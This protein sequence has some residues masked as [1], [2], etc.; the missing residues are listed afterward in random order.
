VRRL[1]GWLV[2]AVGLLNGGRRER[3][4]DDEIES[5]VQMHAD[6]YMRRGLAPDE[7][8]RAAVLKLGSVQAIREQYHDQ[9][10]IPLLEH[11]VQDVR[12]AA[13]TLSRSAGVTAI[14]ILTIALGIAGPT[15]TFTMA[16]AWILE[17]LPFARPAE[18]LDIRNLDKVTGNYGSIAAADFLDFQ[19][20]AHSLQG[21]AAYTPDAV[22]W[23]DGDRAERLRSARATPNFFQM[24]GI[25]PATGRL[26]DA[27]D[28]RAASSRLVV[29]SHA[30][31]R[32]R[33]KS[34]PAIVGRLI[35]LDGEDHTIVGVL[36]ETF[37]FTLL[38]RVNVWRPLVFTPEN[39]TNRR[40]R[41]VTGLGRLRPDRTLEQARGELVAVA[42]HLASTYPDTNAKRDVRV[43]TLADEVRSHHDAGFIVPV[44]FAMV[45]C[46][47]LVACVNVTNIMLAR[48]STRRQEMAVRLALGASRGRIV[49]QWLVE[50]TLLFVVASAIGA[51]L[52][53]Y[54]A[55]WITHAIPEDNRQYLRNNAVLSVD[56]VVVL[57]A[58]ALGA[59]SGTL[60]GWLPAW[61]GAKTDVIVDLRDGAARATTNQA[62]AR[63][64]SALVISEVAFALALLI[65]ASLLVQTS[66]NISR[67]D[68]GFDPQDLLTFHISLESRRY[69]QPA[70]RSGFYEALLND[71]AGRPGISHAAAAS[72][73]PFGTEGRGTE[74]FIEGQPDPVPAET[75]GAALSEIS[76]DYPSTVGL[77]LRH[78]RFL[79][80]QDTATS[81]K[82][83]M[84]N[85]TLAARHFAGRDPIGQRLRLARR[86]SDRWTIVG[87][88]S[89]VR[90][91]EMVDPPA[92]QVYVPMTQRPQRE[93]TVVVRSPANPVALVPTVRRAVAALDRAEPVSEVMTME[94]R[95]RRVTGPYSVMGTFVTFFGAITLLLA[96]VGVY[97][98]IAYS[99]AQRT[100]E[101]GIRMALGAR[102]ADVAALVL[103]QIRLFL[104]AGF[105]PGLAIA[106]ALGNAMKAIL[107]GVTP[108][109]WRLYVLMMV[110]LTTVA[111][112]AAT[113]PARRAVSIDPMTAL[114]YE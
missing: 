67:F 28:A 71:L 4:F 110:V 73:V 93:M 56:R 87:V 47:F 21:M 78:G 49:R 12:Y 8:R 13:R 40:Q 45:M 29:V 79:N 101:I 9:R 48:A 20:G 62:G 82:A 99:F 81:P 17:P 69:E 7:A 1:R 52:A 105:L 19:S 11:A 32:D 92:P 14:A 41:V 109:D 74:F 89:D 55:D 27:A 23:T 46:V 3:E 34:D 53:V 102:R 98:V 112:I 6:E 57:F 59:L 30:M 111:V 86:A 35:R 54:G 104:F 50:H 64:R 2:R 84:I 44:L 68:V 37:Q 96:G 75:P 26:F 31:W 91:Y 103:K 24:L 43:V 63:L 106:V 60:F 94:D 38:G 76:A 66:R 15:V 10:S 100:R 108:T 95:I 88:V 42:R 33:F 61:S 107:F 77:R 36:P 39:A 80:E 70:S 90:N 58:L 85:E 5:H 97:G 72:L 22:R 18:L 51:A 113:V 25:Q 16:K 114:R 65:S 83:I